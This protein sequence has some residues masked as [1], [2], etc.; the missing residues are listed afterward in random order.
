MFLKGTEI[1]IGMKILSEQ[2]PA[3]VEVADALLGELPEGA[4]FKDV[5]LADGSTRRCWEGFEYRVELAD[6]EKGD[7]V[8]SYDF[9]DNP[10][11]SDC[12]VEGQV[13]DFAQMEGC[14]RYVILV[15]RR[16]FKGR[17][18]TD[19]H[20]NMVYPPVNGTRCLLGGVTHGVR[21]IG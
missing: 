21:K 11:A 20:A 16:V 7:R 10:K 13:V 15:D 18:L 8:R 2:T 3:F 1:E 14:Q 19:Y 9:P 4:M 6:I 12:Y 5:H 17:E